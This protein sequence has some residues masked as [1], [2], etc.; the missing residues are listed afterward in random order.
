MRRP[1]KHGNGTG[2]PTLGGRKP[3]LGGRKPNPILK[4][5]KA[6]EFFA[7]IAEE[8]EEAADGYRSQLY[9]FAQR[10]YGIGLEFMDNL[11]EFHRFMG[12]EYWA[13]VRQKPKDDQIMKA[14]LTFAMNADTPQKRTKVTKIA[15]GLDHCAEEPPTDA[16]E[17]AKYISESVRNQIFEITG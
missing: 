7:K 5:R 6:A 8:Y 10:C 11:D 4:A 2:S 13:N 12:D 1:R 16:G 14:V 15:K 3:T 17:V 9:Q